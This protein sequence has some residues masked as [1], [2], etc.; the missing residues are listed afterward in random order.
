MFYMVAEMTKQRE[1]TKNYPS[2]LT[3]WSVNRTSEDSIYNL[4]TD[5]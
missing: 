3:D 2:M 1:L 5:F 4:L